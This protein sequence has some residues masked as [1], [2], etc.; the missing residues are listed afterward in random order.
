MFIFAKSILLGFVASII[1]MMISAIFAT[2]LPLS[3]PSLSISSI[4]SFVSS[5]SLPTLLS[6]SSSKS[7]SSSSPASHSSIISD[8]DE[9]FPAIGK[10]RC[11]AVS[12]ITTFLPSNSKLT[13]TT[14]LV[15]PGTF[16]TIATFLFAK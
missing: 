12:K 13:S 10:N 7:D 14:S 11:P 6:Y 15:V 2:F 16:E 5:E 4:K 1:S 3:M 8:V 9:V